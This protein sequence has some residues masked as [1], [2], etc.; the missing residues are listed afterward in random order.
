YGLETVRLRYFSVFGPRLPPAGRYSGQVACILKALLAGDRP[1]LH[2]GGLDPQDLIYVDD[3]VHATLLAATV[4]RARGRVYNI[5]G[6]RS[7]TPLQLLDLMNGLLGTDLPPAGIYPGPRYDLQSLAD[8]TKAEVEL[9]FC[10]GT[11]LEQGLRRCVAGP[12]PGRSR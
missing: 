4:P 12:A 10:P 7:T 2:G 5:A 8:I 11:D 6:G 9:G 3:V 1:V